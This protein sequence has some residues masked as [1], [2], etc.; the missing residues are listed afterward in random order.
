MKKTYEIIESIKTTNETIST[1]ENEI[2]NASYK[3]K[4]TDEMIEKSHKLQTLKISVKIMKDNFRI[5]FVSETM[6]IIE[7]I[8]AKYAGKKYGEKTK[9]KIRE[10]FKNNNIAFYVSGYSSLG[11]EINIAPLNDN[12]CCYARD[13]IVLKYPYKMHFT[14][15]NN[16]IMALPE[17]LKMS[18]SNY[19]DNEIEHAE[20]I[21][22]AFIEMKNKYDEFNKSMNE[23]N[24]M[25]P[26]GMKQTYVSGFNSYMS[27]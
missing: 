22:K 12:G 23:Y 10:E 18:H 13:Y 5:A 27:L 19:I 11:D 14:D 26:D 15:E 4:T 21:Q 7:N 20:K 25:L 1:L 17:E 9:E 24:H 16:K 2:V 6:P 3:E 8:I